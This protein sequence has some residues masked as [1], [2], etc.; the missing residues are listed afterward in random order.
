[1]QWQ[2]KTKENRATLRLV[3]SKS[4]VRDKDI[5]ETKHKRDVEFYQYRSKATIRQITT[6]DI[7][8]E[9]HKA[10]RSYLDKLV[11]SY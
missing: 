7:M 8:N 3:L 2:I 1:M 10:L 5:V 6:R 4:D 11:A 9:I